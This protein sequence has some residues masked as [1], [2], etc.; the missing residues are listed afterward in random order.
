MRNWIA[1]F[2]RNHRKTPGRLGGSRWWIAGGGGGGSGSLGALE[3]RLLFPGAF[4]FLSSLFYLN[5]P[6]T[7]RGLFV[8]AHMTRRTD[9]GP[10]WLLPPYNTLVDEE[11][12]VFL[13]QSTAGPGSWQPAA[14]H[15]LLSRRHV[16][17]RTKSEEK[18]RVRF[19][20]DPALRGLQQ[21]SKQ[22]SKTG[23]LR[24]DGLL[25]VHAWPADY[26]SYFIRIS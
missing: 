6:S 20:H 8:R 9:R 25:L 22:A 18:D 26:T 15:P 7:P 19:W 13:P 1:P 4:H 12:V 21:S 24:D 5:K 14:G 16:Y 23:D 17:F 10:R 3:N 11:R 2:D